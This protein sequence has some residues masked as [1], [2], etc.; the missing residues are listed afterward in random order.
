MDYRNLN[1]FLHIVETGSFSR[2]AEALGYTQSTVSLQVQALEAELDSRLFDRI[3]HTITLT[4]Q[5]HRLIPHA[6][7][8]R[9]AMEALEQDFHSGEA[10]NGLIRIGSADSLCE[11]MMKL[12]YQEFYNNYPHIKLAFTTGDTNDT[13]EALARN[14]VDV[15]FTLDAH[16][17]RNDMVI[18]KEAPVPV[19]I[20]AAASSPLAGK[21]GILPDE[22][23]QYPFLLT[24]KGM[25]YR[26]EL[27]RFFA[28]HSMEIVPALETGRTDILARAAENGS[29]ISFLPDFVTEDLVQAGKLV[30]LDVA[31]FEPVVWKQLIYHRNK[32]ISRSL[33]SFIEFVADHEFLW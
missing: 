5:G 32:W 23:I 27:D 2:A 6:Q 14:E 18:A 16:I 10:A 30:R 33:N 31:G 25:S 8:V 4:E 1:A 7:R 24:E 21:K 9:R 13:V 17:H 26:R 20:V 19:H 12:N 15:I 3:N 22:L 11:K 29:G 28:D